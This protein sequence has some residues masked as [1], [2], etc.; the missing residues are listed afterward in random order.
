MPIAACQS[1]RDRRVSAVSAED[2]LR[3]ALSCADSDRLDL[4]A[5]RA[6]AGVHLLG[7]DGIGL[8]RDYASSELDECL[9]NPTLVGADIEDEPARGCQPAEEDLLLLTRGKVAPIEDTLV[10][11][12]CAAVCPYPAYQLFG[13]LASDRMH[14]L[15]RSRSWLLC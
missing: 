15:N 1:S 11:V 3:A 8:D 14:G 6:I 12:A 7:Q 9:R 13:A 5:A 2:Q 10:A 4:N